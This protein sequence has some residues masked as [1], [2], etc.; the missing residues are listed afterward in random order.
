MLTILKNNNVS[1]YG[2]GI[3]CTF[4]NDLKAEKREHKGSGECP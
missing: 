4:A 1:Q 3:F 2:S